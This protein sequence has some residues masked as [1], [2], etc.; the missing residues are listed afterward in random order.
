[1]FANLKNKIKEEIGSD[2]STVVRN[3]GSV[4][5]LKHLSQVHIPC[6]LFLAGFQLTSLLEY[7]SNAIN[8]SFIFQTGSTSSISGSQISLDGSREDN[9]LSPVPSNRLKQENSFDLKLGDGT[10]LTLK[11]IKRLENREDEWRKRLQKREAE[12]L[13]KME[14]KE[15][16][17]RIK[18]LEKEKEWKKNTEK[19]EK[20]KAKLIEDRLKAESAK[21]SLEIALN[22]AEG[23]H[24]IQYVCKSYNVFCS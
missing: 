6:S 14:K 2:V 11:D 21:C 13:K 20:E 22:E 4:R 8:L 5:G 9:S 7:V 1:M 17:F 19:F 12:L 24:T 18:M 15:E 3:A 16:E 23:M 10:P